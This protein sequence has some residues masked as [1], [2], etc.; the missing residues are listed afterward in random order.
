MGSIRD[1]V[2][3]DYDDG[4]RLKSD[5]KEWLDS[6]SENV[7]V[8]ESII[9][10]LLEQL[11]QKEKELQGYKGALE[12]LSSMEAFEMPRFMNDVSDKELLARIDYARTALA[13]LGGGESE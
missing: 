5:A 6:G 8:A 10:G 11:E 1:K 2:L 3:E 12:R 7:Y 9:K 4:K 13:N